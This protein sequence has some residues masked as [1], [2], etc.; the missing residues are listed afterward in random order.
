[1]NFFTTFS[2][3]NKARRFS[4]SSTFF[5]RFAYILAK[6]HIWEF[7]YVGK[8]SIIW[9]LD[10]TRH[11]NC[12]ICLKKI[13]G[14]I[15]K[16]RFFFCISRDS[17]WRV[18]KIWVQLFFRERAYRPGDLSGLKYFF[19]SQQIFLF[20]IVKSLV[21]YDLGVT[22]ILKKGNNFILLFYDVSGFSFISDS[23]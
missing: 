19:Q 18:V 4:T 12:L 16:S 1:M 11:F 15:L 17:L 7:I 5:L 20:V 23:W 3:E 2:P 6:H 22:S 8:P 10:L 21:S 14:E 13:K 9:K